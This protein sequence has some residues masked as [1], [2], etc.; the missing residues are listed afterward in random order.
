MLIVVFG[1]A[2]ASAFYT[3]KYYTKIILPLT[4]ILGS[5]MFVRGV[6]II[7]D[8]GVPSN[9]IMFGESQNILG[10]FYYLLGFGFAIFLGVSF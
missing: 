9:F 5:Y 10:V 8:G 2:G 3:H 4:V 1:V 7:I 6:S